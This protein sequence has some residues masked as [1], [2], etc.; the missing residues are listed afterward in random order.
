LELLASLRGDGKGEAVFGLPGMAPFRRSRPDLGA[1]P[2]FRGWL[3]EKVRCPA[4]WSGLLEWALGHHALAESLDAAF[5][6]AEA[7]SGTDVWFWTS[8]GEGLHS[9]GALHGGRAAA[10][11]AHG[12]LLQRRV[13]L[14]ESEAR[15]AALDRDLSELAKSAAGFEARRDAQALEAE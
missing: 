10:E 3:I 5:G 7:V 15:L 12:G 6:L 2:G 4:E 11:S 1:R 8:E 9:G 14:Q 13:Q